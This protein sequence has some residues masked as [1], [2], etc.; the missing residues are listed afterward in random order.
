VKA[1]AITG[2]RE[3]REIIRVKKERGIPVTK[4][5]KRAGHEIRAA[6]PRGSVY[7]LD[8]SEKYEEIVAVTFNDQRSTR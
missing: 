4:L 3:E 5:K 6:D 2:E 7:L 1:I 8:K